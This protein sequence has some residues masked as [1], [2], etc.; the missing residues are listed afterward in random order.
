MLR[1][2]VSLLVTL[3]LF[4]SISA[5]VMAGPRVYARM[6][7]DG[8]FPRIFAV[9]G[10]VPA[11][12]VVLQLTLALVVVWISGLAQLLG[13]IGFTLGLSAAAT[14]AALFLVRRREGAATVPIPGYPWV[15]AF[16]VIAT[17]GTAGFMMLREPFVA[18]MG[19]VTV[20]AGVPMYWLM[21]R[22]SSSPANISSPNQR[23]T[24]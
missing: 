19:L 5:M 9:R 7:E 18:A 8:L 24:R 23:S 16:F 12:A 10:D 15:P 3:A 14:V 21:R 4:T 2:A 17:L 11:A 6:A 13:Y 22:K 1:R 20:A